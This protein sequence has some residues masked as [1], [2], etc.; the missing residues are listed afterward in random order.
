MKYLH[1]CVCVCVRGCVYVCVHMCA[2]VCVALAWLTRW[3]GYSRVEFV[4]FGM[5][6][7]KAISYGQCT[8]YIRTF[9]KG[10]PILIYRTVENMMYPISK[11]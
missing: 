4:Y 5:C 1:V 6:L 7:R 11:H 9:M 3:P 2:C 10:M 8:M